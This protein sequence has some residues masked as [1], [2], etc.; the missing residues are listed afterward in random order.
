LKPGDL[1]QS[2]TPSLIVKKNPFTF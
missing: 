1:P 2:Q